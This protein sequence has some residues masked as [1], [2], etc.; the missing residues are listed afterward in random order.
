[1]TLF[2]LLTGL[3]ILVAVV[4]LLPALLRGGKREDDSVDRQAQNIAIARERLRELDAEYRRGELGEAEFTQAK[5]ELELALAEDLSDQAQ[6]AQ[7]SSGIPVLI[8]LLVLVP[9]VTLG[10]Y[11][12]VGAPEHVQ[13]AGPSPTVTQ[14]T[15]PHA[16]S[17][18]P[19]K[20]PSIAEMVA[21]L[22]ERLEREPNNADGWYML[23]RSYMSMGRYSDA[24]TALEKL[25]QQ[26]GDHPTAL[27]M[28]ADTK[29]M[30]N[31]GRMS[32]EPER[33]VLA[34]L[35]QQPDDVTALWLAGKAAQDRADHS[36]AL[37]FW[38]RAEAGL[39]D[40]PE[41]LNELRGL[42]ARA[43]QQGAQAPA[44]PVAAA[45]AG[46]PAINVSISLSPDM[47]AK[48]KPG[49]LVFVFARAV[50][51]PPRPLAAARV[52]VSDLPAQVTLDDS[53]AMMPQ[54]KLSGFAE[55]KVGARVALSGQPIAQSGD[56][57]SDPQIVAVGPG[58][59]VSL[60]IDQEVP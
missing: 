9:A 41:M 45:I 51:G 47:A 57:Q 58:V 34:A 4:L 5:E 12:F 27:I 8:S 33:L 2:W 48:A 7:G 26:V 54:M 23:A 6:L 1:M 59:D 18:A 29:A 53:M 20:Q 52:K 30:I 13:V 37:A 28:L 46:G 56:L 31:G 39:Q 38:R 44:E 42:M 3:L 25:R 35:A 14:Q 50:T 11:L 17:G 49:D 21:T 19:G 16:G 60:V 55:V 36:G 43:E 24:V 40:Q 15:N 22:A 10:V 32:G